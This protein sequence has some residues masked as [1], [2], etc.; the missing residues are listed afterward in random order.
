MKKTKKTII[1]ALAAATLTMSAL[2]LA[3]CSKPG[4]ETPP[5][6]TPGA[7]G[8]THIVTFK[9][10]GG[11]WNTEGTEVAD[12][13][14]TTDEQGKISR[15]AFPANPV[16]ADYTFGGWYANAEGTGTSY[17]FASTFGSDMDLY[18]KWTSNEVDPPV[19]D[20]TFTITLNAGEGAT[21]A[22][23]STVTTGTDGKLAELPAAPTKANYTFNGWF[24][25]ATDGTQITTDTVFTADSTIYAQWT[26]NGGTITPQPVTYT[27][28]LNADGGTLAGGVETVTTGTDGKLA[29]LPAAPTKANHTFDGWYTVV[30]GGGERVTTS[31]VFTKDDTIVAHWTADVVELEPGDYN[32]YVN[33][34]IVNNAL[35]AGNDGPSQTKPENLIF[36]YYANNVKLKKGDEVKFELKDITI[37]KLWAKGG[38]AIVGVTGTEA[39]QGVDITGDTVTVLAD[40]TYTVS[41]AQYQD[42][43]AENKANIYIGPYTGPFDDQG[44]GEQIVADGYYIVGT[45]GD[46][47]PLA[48]NKGAGPTELK[49]EDGVTVY[50]HEYKFTV[51]FTAGAGFKI[52][53]FE[54]G[55]SKTDGWYAHLQSDLPASVAT[56]GGNDNTA[57]NITVVEAGNYEVYL[58]LYVAG[59]HD[60]WVAKKT[61]TGGGDEGGDKPVDPPVTTGAQMLIG[62]VASETKFT[63]KTTEFTGDQDDEYY[64]QNVTLAADAVLSFKVDGKDVLLWRDNY[65]AANIAAQPTDASVAQSSFGITKAGKFTVVIKHYEGGADKWVLSV[66]DPDYKPVV[67]TAT[68]VFS[69]KDQLTATVKVN[70][71]NKNELMITGLVLKAE[72]TITIKYEGKVVEIDKTVSGCNTA[73]A[74][75][76]LADG[77]SVK[78]VA[79]TYDL[80]YTFATATTDAK[81][82]WVSKAVVGPSADKNASLTYTKSFG[83]TGAYVVGKFY[84]RGMADYAWGDGYAMTEKSTGVYELKNIYLYE[85]DQFK[86]R[87]GSGDSKGHSIWKQSDQLSWEG[88]NANVLT[89][90]E[91]YYTITIDTSAGNNDYEMKVT[92]HG[93]TAA[94]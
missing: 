80:Y 4:E 75:E 40:G 70:P 49:E 11:A 88:N 58:K 8:T 71:S 26:E 50:G 94:A 39:E 16:R 56:G 3:A 14:I 61:T 55:E 45:D 38:T 2:G 63:H 74:A 48:A 5:T 62:S 59:G 83:T 64:A 60:I 47:K 42:Q 17:T 7:G 53:T 65:D 22:G 23:E 9:V 21:L 77:K 89:G 68:G 36:N 32:L 1:A 92:Y 15:E 44:G 25:A 46:W 28:T 86:V 81:K 51:A 33:G 54:N 10:N 24:D 52:A 93:K 27:I 78:L 41:I 73:G 87:L 57:P 12:K 85:G 90:G 67:D 79:G 91:G 84:S 43:V 31:T 6:P 69:G 66:V 29:T 13:V 76:F 37:S 30:P 82:L 18:A 35:L 72:T 19:G 20:T 34:K